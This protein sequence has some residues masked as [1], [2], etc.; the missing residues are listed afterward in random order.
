MINTIIDILNSYG[1]SNNEDLIIPHIFI[2]NIQTSQ[3]EIFLH[4][5][6]IKLI[7]NCSKNIKFLDNYN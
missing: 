2:G 7:V 5:N 6:N 1:I 4:K 3:D